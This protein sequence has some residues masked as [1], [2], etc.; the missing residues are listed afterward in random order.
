MKMYMLMY[1]VYGHA[2]KNNARAHTHT[3]TFT[4]AHTKPNTI[5]RVY[6]IGNFHE[7]YNSFYKSNFN[8]TKIYSHT[9]IC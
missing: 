6:F 9:V 2:L 1:N 3:H 4:H 5:K 8:A 7:N